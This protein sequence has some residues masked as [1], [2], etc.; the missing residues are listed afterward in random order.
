[1]QGPLMSGPYV[2]W[3]KMAFIDPMRRS[4][5]YPWKVES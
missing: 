3:N 1:M 5:N 2:L 4:K